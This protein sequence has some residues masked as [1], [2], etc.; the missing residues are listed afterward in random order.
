MKQPTRREFL[1]MAG[2]AVAGTALAA[3]APAPQPVAQP[4]KP[5]ESAEQPK[6]P[7]TTAPPAKPVDLDFWYIWGGDGGKAMEAVSAEFEKRNPG[8]KMHP[9]T[10]GGVILDKTIA[11]YAAGAPPA[12][13]DL[14]L[15]APLAARGAL[16]EI[17]PLLAASSVINKD[18]YFDAQWDGTKWAGRNW[19][20]P[21]NEGLGWLG[22]INNRA[23][24]KKAGLDSAKPPKTFADLRVWADKMTV[25]TAD[26]RIDTLGC[27][28]RGMLTYP[29]C[30]GLVMGLRYFDG[31][32]LKY[33]FDDERWV[34][35][36]NIDK[37][38]YNMVGPEK[39]ADFRA[40]FSGQAIANPAAAGKVGVWTDG[41]WAPGSLVKNAAKGMEWDINFMVDGTGKGELPYFA[42]THTMMI[43]K[44]AAV[45]EAWKFLEFSSTDEYIKQVYA[46]SGF[47]MGTKS[48]I[49]SLGSTEQYPGLDFYLSGL[50]KANRI[51]GLASDPNWYLSWSEFMN[52]EEAVGFGKVNPKEGL[53]NLQKLLTAEYQRLVK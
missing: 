45:N 52:L 18:N 49:K 37:S 20:V 43:M 33:T 42:G 25:M 27:E 16:V 38:F 28:I 10:V 15:C 51:W 44:G 22:M 36:L 47:I 26:G 14:I 11:A 8:V 21:A 3:C 23:L 13:V 50:A 1:R 31:N 12:I 48:F 53:A 17:T 34:Q 46:L 5:A 19:G 29:D 32:A 41:S 2:T 35:A 4:A 9:L 6:A 30:W 39:L 7:V 24:V 40:S